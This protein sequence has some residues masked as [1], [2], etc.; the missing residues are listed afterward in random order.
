MKKRET[1]SH[2]SNNAFDVLTK[3]ISG[4]PASVTL[5]NISVTPFHNSQV[6]VISDE[7]HFKVG[8]RRPPH[9]LNHYH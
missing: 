5:K 9:G 8:L 1:H 7:S 2:L 3:R 4:A 6:A